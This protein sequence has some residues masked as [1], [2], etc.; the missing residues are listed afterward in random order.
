MAIDMRTPGIRGTHALQCL[1]TL[2]KVG[3]PNRIMGT[4]KGEKAQS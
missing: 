4:G 2:W 1:E 3:K